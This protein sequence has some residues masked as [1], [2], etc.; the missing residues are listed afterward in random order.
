MYKKYAC[1]ETTIFMDF[2]RRAALTF[3]SN[4]FP[5]RFCQDLPRLHEK[6]RLYL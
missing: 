4:N 6:G 1:E 3:I 2:D 5:H